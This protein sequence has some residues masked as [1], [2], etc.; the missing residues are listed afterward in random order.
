VYADDP[1]VDVPAELQKHLVSA[2][3]RADDRIVAGWLTYELATE[4]SS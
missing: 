2:I 1:R 3:D 4:T